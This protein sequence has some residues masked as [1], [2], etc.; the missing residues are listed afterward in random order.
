MYKQFFSYFAAVTITG[1]MAAKEQA[2]EGS[3]S[4]Q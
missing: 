2:H 3:K 1:D 4:A